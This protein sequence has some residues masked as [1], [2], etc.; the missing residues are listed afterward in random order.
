MVFYDMQNDKF[1]NPKY[2]CNNCGYTTI[3]PDAPYK[4]RKKKK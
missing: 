2:Y 1:V 4:K 3:N